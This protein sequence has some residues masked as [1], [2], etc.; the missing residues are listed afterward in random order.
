MPTRELLRAVIGFTIYLLFVP[1]LLFIS[2]GTLNW[3]MAWVYMLLLL[4]S[5]L[6]SRLIA[7][8]RNPDL[9]YE[10][11]RF[12]SSEGTQ[13]WD[14]TLVAIVGLFGPMAMMI[15]A[16][17]DRRLSWS[18]AVPKSGQYLAAI[19]IAIG[20]GIAVWAMVVNRYFSAVARIQQDRDQEVVTEG[21]YRFVRHP[22]YAG[23]L[24]ASLALPFMLDAL[25]AMIPGFGLG[26]ALILR[27][28]L[29]DRMLREELEGYISYMESTP[30]RLIPGIW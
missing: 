19:L 3:G 14:R 10:R 29:E 2:A 16:G 12:S 24:L 20:Y 25:W 26:I 17:L 6:G 5:T 4:I 22:G 9:L 7:W 30:Y 8:K 13:P 1:A 11:A 21:P 27:T 23:A 18:S 15:V 28:Q